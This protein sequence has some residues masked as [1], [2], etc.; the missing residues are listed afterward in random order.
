MP[1]LLIEPGET[2]RKSL[3]SAVADA[4]VEYLL[5]LRTEDRPMRT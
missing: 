4:I 2:A 1:G 3:A 5:A